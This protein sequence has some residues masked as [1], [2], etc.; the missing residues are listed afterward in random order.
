MSKRGEQVEGE[1]EPRMKKSEEIDVEKG[2]MGISYYRALDVWRLGVC[3]G[4]Y[5]RY[6][7]TYLCIYSHLS[8][9]FS[10]LKT[11]SHS[12]AILFIMRVKP[13]HPLHDVDEEFRLKRAASSDA[14]LCSRYAR[15]S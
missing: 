1:R 10:L 7:C 15:L 3:V 14:V 9:V 6:V 11:K 4:G 8:A 2:E 12:S 5:V 13:G